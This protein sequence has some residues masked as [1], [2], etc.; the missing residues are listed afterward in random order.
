MW[1]RCLQCRRI[2][3][4]IVVWGCIVRGE[5]ILGVAVRC[6]VVRGGV[7]RGGVVQ[8]GLV[9]LGGLLSRGPVMFWVNPLV[10]TLGLYLVKSGRWGGVDKTVAFDG[11]VIALTEVRLRVEAGR[12]ASYI[13]IILLTTCA[14]AIGRDLRSAGVHL[15]KDQCLAQ[16]AVVLAGSGVGVEHCVGPVKAS[17]WNFEERVGGRA[18]E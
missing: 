14:P 10:V 13:I 2:G 9:G 5:V 8:G 1:L 18:F 7:V 11:I 6:D 17:H 4:S 16:T 3:G 12:P 15:L